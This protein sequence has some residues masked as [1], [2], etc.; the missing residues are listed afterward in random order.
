M[1][2]ERIG[3]PQQ[4]KP[5]SQPN[6]S[7]WQ[8]RP[9]T[10]RTSAALGMARN[11]AAV[12]FMRRPSERSRLDPAMPCGRRIAAAAAVLP[13]LAAACVRP[14]RSGPPAAKPNCRR[15]AFCSCQVGREGNREG[16]WCR[17]RGL[18]EGSERKQQARASQ[19]PPHLTCAAAKEP[20]A[21]RSA[22]A[23]QACC[24]AA[25]KPRAATVRA[26]E[27][28]AASSPPP[29]AARSASPTAPHC[30]RRCS[31]RCEPRIAEV[32]AERV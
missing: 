8:H 27:R 9:S 16:S 13:A 28:A 22:P 11:S 25:A 6:N 7:N 12:A 20:A 1:L 17:V 21:G 3:T 15:P 32:T 31:R 19:M 14:A 24:P 30:S 26:R 10:P 18:H 2:L 29:A 4:D 23:R 5:N